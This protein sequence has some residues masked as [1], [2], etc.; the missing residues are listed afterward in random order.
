[1]NQIEATKEEYWE[2][3]IVWDQTLPHCASACILHMC[4]LH[5]VPS[6]I[7]L[8]SFSLFSS[9]SLAH[10]LLLFY[11]W[12]ICFLVWLLSSF[13]LLSFFLFFITSKI[14]LFLIIIF[15]FKDFI[16]IYF[17][18]FLSFFLSFFLPFLL[19]CVADRVLV[20]WPGVRPVPLR[21]E[22]RDQG[23]GPPETSWLHGISNG[24]AIPEISISTR[25]PS[26]TQRPASYSAG[27]PMPNT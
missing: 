17:I 12:W 18:F 5:C 9:F 3:A 6:Q 20:L 13:F 19:S 8:V 26:S 24:E 11:H 15:Y 1:M 22:S 7:S 10:C 4:L 27:H 14:F 23:I 25:R 16:S 2:R 21:W